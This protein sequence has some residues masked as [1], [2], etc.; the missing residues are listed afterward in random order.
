[1]TDIDRLISTV[2]QVETQL[3]NVQE[4]QELVRLST[5]Q[6]VK[7][8]GEECDG[9]SGEEARLGLGQEQLKKKIK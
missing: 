3:T 1:M 9:E 4:Q 5:D 8:G 6:V 7:Q 2:V